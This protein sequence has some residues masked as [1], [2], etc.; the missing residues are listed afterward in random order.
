M[1]QEELKEK[2]QEAYETG[3]MFFNRVKGWFDTKDTA[4]SFTVILILIW[5][6][7]Q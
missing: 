1:E 2:H 6:V 3:A 4:L 5:L 7:L